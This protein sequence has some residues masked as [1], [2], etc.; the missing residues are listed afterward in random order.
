[1]GA[2]DKE[3]HRIAW[4]FNNNFPWLGMAICAR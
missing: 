2:G 1:M 3:P 4:Y